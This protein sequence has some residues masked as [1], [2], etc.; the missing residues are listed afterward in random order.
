MAGE[1]DL[2]KCQTSLESHIGS[3]HMAFSTIHKVGY[4]NGEKADLHSHVF[5]LVISCLA[6]MLSHLFFFSYLKVKSEVLQLNTS[7]MAHH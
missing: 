4:K 5:Q 7:Q 2:Q 6:D 3:V 1:A